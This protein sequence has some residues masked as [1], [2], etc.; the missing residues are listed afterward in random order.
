MTCKMTGEDECRCE[1]ITELRVLF[2]DHAVYTMLFLK[3]AI[4]NT[5]DIKFTHKV[6]S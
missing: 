3:S 4:F 1:L 6:C 5:P 2:T